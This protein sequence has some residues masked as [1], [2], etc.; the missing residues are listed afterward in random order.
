[1][2]LR[3]INYQK[4]ITASLLVFSTC[5]YA[6]ETSLQ[7]IL[8]E[9]L[10]R[11]FEILSKA[12]PAAYYM[13]YRVDDK[14]SF[15]LEANF[16]NIIN[17]G[18]SQ[19]RLC[20]PTV[21][22]GSYD[23]DNTRE[24]NSF[25]YGYGQRMMAQVIPINDN[26]VAIKQTLWRL[27]DQAYKAAKLKYKAVENADLDEELEIAD[28]SKEQP[29]EYSESFEGINIDTVYWKNVVK[30]ASMQFRGN[31]DI[32]SGKVYLSFNHTRKTF[33]SSEGTS[34]TQNL[35]L[36]QLHVVG[37]VVN[38]KNEVV[39]LY[40][41]FSGPTL[42]DLVSSD[43]IVAKAKELVSLLSELKKAP[44]A[45]PYT[46]PA[47]L[48]PRVSA[49][50]FHE[51]F[52]HRIEGHRL[53]SDSD[54]QTF[55]EKV[56]TKIL[57]EFINIYSDPTINSF[58]D[59]KLNGVYAYDDQ[60]VKA[61]RVNVVEKGVL[62]TF[63]MSRSP[64]E[65]FSNSNGH[66]RSEV[67]AEPVARQSNLI[68]ESEVGLSES[69]LRQLLIKECKKQGKE[70][71]YYFKEVTGGFTQT[72]R[73]TTNA[74]NIMPTLVYRVFADGR[75]DELVKGVD[76]IGTPLAMFAEV[77]AA[78]IEVDVF[79]GIC[80]AESGN[81]PVSAIAP[82]LLVRRIETQK[83]PVNERKSAEPILA[84]PEFEGK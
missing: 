37:E 43:S 74:F 59:Q 81:I 66:G 65:E 36:A 22:I 46:G 54:G 20:Q 38:D 31:D 67:G 27:T 71:G 11:E 5:V 35:S 8:K 13:D 55:K 80:G 61:K 60:G 48:H 82:S 10:D 1:M 77:V 47:I 75:S 16:G 79:N 24:V 62:N 14:R 2:M 69:E 73:Y 25:G 17:Q 39:S 26:P 56:G 83:K 29:A 53:K 52:G 30:E 32:I 45:E 76:L 72:S 49:V 4:L 18:A 21:R 41:S 57:P 12:E 63:L 84:S 42:N 78:G 6:Q 3:M 40:E 9:E 7:S 50:F 64:I 44:F 33:V 28:F 19:L 51:I 68:I 70:Y 15:S 58:E 34:I 23:K